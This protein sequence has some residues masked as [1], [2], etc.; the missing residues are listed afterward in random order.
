MS[1][2]GCQRNEQFGNRLCAHARHAFLREWYGIGYQPKSPEN[3]AVIDVLIKADRGDEFN[4]AFLEV[5][6][7]HHF[8]LLQPVNGCRPN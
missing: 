8:T 2:S 1:R 5:F 6:S 3:Q 4:H 7:R